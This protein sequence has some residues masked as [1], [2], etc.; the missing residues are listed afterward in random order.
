MIK[1][2]D[3][4]KEQ[5]GINEGLFDGIKGAVKGAVQ[6]YRDAQQKPAQPAPVQNQPQP[7]VQQ[8]QPNQK[9]PEQQPQKPAEQQKA[10]YQGTPAEHALA[11]LTPVFR[12][13]QQNDPGAAE[14]IKGATMAYKQAPGAE[15][16]KQ[17][18]ATILTSD[19][20]GRSAFDAIRDV[21]HHVSDEVYAGLLSMVKSYGFK[22]YEPRTREQSEIDWMKV[23]GNQ[24]P[25][26]KN[27]T[28][29]LMPGLFDSRNRLVMLAQVEME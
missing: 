6:G 15:S 24:T 4:L 25:R 29:V 1:F 18:Y 16:A 13:L 11:S 28:R 20:S 19:R 23:I 7:V 2:N 21:N 22:L 5:A 27:I 14:S 9:V 12:Q 3:W 17:L 26:T 10:W 8:P